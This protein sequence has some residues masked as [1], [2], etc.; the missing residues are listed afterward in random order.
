[1]MSVSKPSI[2]MRI[3]LPRAKAINFEEETQFPVDNFI[4][5]GSFS[6]FPSSLPLFLSGCVMLP[7]KTTPPLYSRAP[8][9]TPFSIEQQRI[10]HRHGSPIT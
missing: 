9:S 7:K 5:M 10:Y 6:R 8:L 2:L 3:E 4:F 1:M